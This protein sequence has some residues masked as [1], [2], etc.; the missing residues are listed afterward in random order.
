MDNLVLNDIEV[1]RAVRCLCLEHKFEEAI[2]L[3]RKVG[4]PK[5]RETLML[6][7]TSFKHTR[8]KQYQAA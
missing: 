4:D 2:D 3:A 5:C 1:I 7:C 8:I 6:I